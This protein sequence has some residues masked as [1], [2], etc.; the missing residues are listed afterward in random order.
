MNAISPD[1]LV[2][3]VRR[4]AAFRESGQMIAGA[5]RRDPEAVGEWAK[6]LP[7]AASVVVYC[8]HGHEVSQGVASALAE[9]G[10]GARYLEG[11]IEAW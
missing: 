6:R 7:R 9:R 3:D 1:E 8:V 5:L 2:V 4:A 10:L 11:G